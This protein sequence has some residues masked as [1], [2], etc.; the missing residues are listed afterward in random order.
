AINKI[1]VASSDPK[2]RLPIQKDY[3]DINYET[4]KIIHNNMKE[5]A[6][7][8]APA[9][10]AAIKCIIFAQCS[11]FKK[12]IK[13]KLRNGSSIIIRSGWIIL[14]IVCTDR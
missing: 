13:N 11:F 10:N 3:I 9:S 2:K 6:T 5:Q 4:D 8:N 1:R 7:N 14:L 12:K